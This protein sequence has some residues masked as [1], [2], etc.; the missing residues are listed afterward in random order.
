MRYFGFRMALTCSSGYGLAHT[1]NKWHI[2]FCFELTF[3]TI[4]KPLANFAESTIFRI[5]IKIAFPVEFKS[6]SVFLI[7]CVMKV[8]CKWKTA[9]NVYSRNS[10]APKFDFGIFSQQQQQQKH[11]LAVTYRRSRLCRAPNCEKVKM[12]LAG[13]C[14]LAKV[15]SLLV[16]C[17]FS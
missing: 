12:A 13:S 4:F 8:T 2:F 11:D 15:D 3:K 16:F 9:E 14:T 17:Y 7:K 1:G 10:Y 5:V 6:F